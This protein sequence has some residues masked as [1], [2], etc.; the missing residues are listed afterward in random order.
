MNNAKA[1]TIPIKTK[2]AAINFPITLKIMTIISPIASKIL[3]ITVPAFFRPSLLIS[4]IFFFNVS[5][6]SFTLF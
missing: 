3:P 6:S 4:S 2:M 5:I 1:A